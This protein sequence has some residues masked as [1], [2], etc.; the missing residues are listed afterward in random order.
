MECS[1]IAVFQKDSF[2]SCGV[3]IPPN[4]PS[5]CIQSG[6][7]DQRGV[8]HVYGDLN[9]GGR[10]ETLPFSSLIQFPLALFCF[11]FL[12]LIPFLE[13]CNGMLLAYNT[14]ERSLWLRSHGWGIYSTK[15]VQDL[16]LSPNMGRWPVRGKCV[17]VGFE[18]W[19]GI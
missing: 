3:S 1:W 10:Y 19:C 11:Y 13:H 4:S 7:D 8:K 14:L 6:Q 18:I 16:H 5:T 17:Y 12:K 9:I 15:F 2:G